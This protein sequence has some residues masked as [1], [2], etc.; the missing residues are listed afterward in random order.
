MQ[1]IFVKLKNKKI[2]Q[3]TTINA[4]TNK[5]STDD[6]NSLAEFYKLILA[7]FLQL[8]PNFNSPEEV[9]KLE[10]IGLLQTAIMKF[11][12]ILDIRNKPIKSLADFWLSTITDT[13][14][15][16]AHNRLPTQS[17]QIDQTHQYWSSPT[18]LGLKIPSLMIV[19]L[20]RNVITKV[21]CP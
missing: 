12:G 20:Y 10:S 11:L 21:Q 2:L 3:N 7:F 5:C 6:E 16:R 18:K 8:Q 14:L 17:Q 1:I 19:N 13:K 15:R 4:R 9:A